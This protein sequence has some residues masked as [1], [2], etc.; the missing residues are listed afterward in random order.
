MPSLVRLEDAAKARRLVGVYAALWNIAPRPEGTRW[1]PWP[2][3][4]PRSG[5]RARPARSASDSGRCR[6]RASGPS[7]SRSRG[8]DGRPAD[9]CSACTRITEAFHDWSQK[10]SSF[11]GAVT[12]GDGIAWCSARSPRRAIAVIEILEQAVLEILPRRPAGQLGVD[13]GRALDDVGQ[14]LAASSAPAHRRRP[15]APRARGQARLRAPS[16]R[17]RCWCR[18][19]RRPS[20]LRRT[21]SSATSSAWLSVVMPARTW[22]LRSAQPSSV[23]R[24][25]RWPWPRAARRWVCKSEPPW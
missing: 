8:A 12:R 24:D 16:P 21:G 19:A 15:R 22:P 9:W 14:R 5:A 20:G 4:S 17:R 10:R 6:A 18:P 3:P 13:R 11:T 1:S 7:A 2:S 23:R 25:T